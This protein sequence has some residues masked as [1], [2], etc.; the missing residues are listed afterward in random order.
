MKLLFKTSNTGGSTPTIGASNFKEHY[1]AINSNTAWKTIQPSIRRATETYLIPY[2]SSELYEDISDKYDA[3]EELDDEQTVFLTACQDVVAFY[4]I[5]LLSPEL[6]VS[7]GD[8]GVV[9]KGSNQQPVLPV[10]QWRYKEFKYDLTKKADAALD[11]VLELLESYVHDEVEYFNLWKNSTAYGQVRTSFFNSAAAFSKYVNI[12]NSRRLFNSLGIDIKRAEEKIDGVIGEYQFNELVEMVNAGIDLE[13]PLDM[14]LEKIRRFVAAQSVISSTPRLFVTLDA[15]GLTLS[16][17]T[18]G[19]DAGNHLSSAFRGAEAVEGY[20]QQL[21]A[22]AGA[23]Y[24]D[25]VNFIYANIDDLPLI[26]DSDEYQAYSTAHTHRIIHSHD[27][28]GVFL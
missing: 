27:G 4:T 19:Y 20:L 26:S 18:D 3:S 22:D 21:K 14:L 16:S 11:Y 25:L 10:A 28:G 5:L 17:Y 12:N 15:R 1:A 7:I 13:A 23:Y 6:N 24:Q 8:M 2:I 9:E